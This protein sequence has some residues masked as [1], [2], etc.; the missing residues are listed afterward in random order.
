MMSEHVNPSEVFSTT[1]FLI[2]SCTLP[3]DK[4]KEKT[5]TFEIEYKS[6]SITTFSFAVDSI[7]NCTTNA[8]H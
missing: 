5:L 2:C 1:F 8:H 3:L 4:V 6:E 7:S